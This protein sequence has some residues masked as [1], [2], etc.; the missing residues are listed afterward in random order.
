MSKTRPSCTPET[1][2]KRLLELCDRTSLLSSNGAAWNGL[3]F[4]YSCSRNPG[5]LPEEIFFPQ[6]VIHIYTD[7]P[8]GYF[9][10]TRI[11]GR[12]QT[13]SMV[14]GHSLIIP[15][16]VSYWLADNQKSTAITLGIDSD[17]LD[18]SWEL[19]SHVPI[20]DPLIYHIGLALKA[21]LERNL[22]NSRL[23]AESAATFLATHLLH[24]YAVPKQSQPDYQNGLS[25]QNLQLVIDY[26][27]AHLDGNIGLTDLAHLVQMSA[28]HFSRLFKQ[29][30]GYSPYQF[31]IKC[32]VQRAKELL[33][34]SDLSINEITYQVGF[35]SQSHLTN[36]CKR[37][38]GATPKIIR[39]K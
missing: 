27:Y 39:Q 14:T 2:E 7:T 9:A 29:S 26:I 34:N 33:L 13:V 23:Y 22:Q 19:Q 12:L 30:T 37:L 21:E 20:F 18:N 31:V 8:S 6:D 3:R 16:G 4:Q 25:K 28:Y 5:A 15:R 35:S 10:Q 24:H 36:H 1:A 32:R 17:L 38:L 11:D